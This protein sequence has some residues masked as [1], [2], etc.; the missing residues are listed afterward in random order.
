LRAASARHPNARFQLGEPL[1]A[2]TGVVDAL[3]ERAAAARE[4]ARDDQD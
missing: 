3:L 2:H 4:I 1:G